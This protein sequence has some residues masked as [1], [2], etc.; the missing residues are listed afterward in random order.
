VTTDHAR[1]L[2]ADALNRLRHA[3]ATGQGEREALTHASWALNAY[4]AANASPPVTDGRCVAC[5]VGLP[6]GRPRRYCS[7][8]CR[9]AFSRSAH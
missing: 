5:G 8:E 7:R 1:R 4:D 2:V 6:A 3:R 9:V